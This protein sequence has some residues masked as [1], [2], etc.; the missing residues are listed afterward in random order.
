MWARDRSRKSFGGQG[1]NR[2]PTAE[3]GWS[4]ASGA[5]HLLNLPTV[6]AAPGRDCG[7][8]VNPP[9]DHV[10]SGADD[11]TRTRNLLFTK[12]LLYQLSYV[13][14]TRR[15]IP[16]MTPSAPGNDRAGRSDG[17]SVGG[18]AAA[19]RSG[20]AS[21]VGTARGR[22]GRGLVLGRSRTAFRAESRWPAASCGLPGAAWLSRSAPL[23]SAPCSASAARWLV[24]R[25]PGGDGGD[26]SRRAPVGRSGPPLRVPPRRVLRP[27]P[28]VRRGPGPAGSRWATASNSST[29]PATAALSEPIAPRIG[30]RM[31]RSQRLPD[32]RPET[33]ALAADDDAPADR[34]GRSGARSAARPLSAPAIRS[35]FGRGGRRGRRAGRRPGTSRRCSTAPADAL[36]AAGAE[37]RLAAG[38]EHDAVDAGRLGAAQ[39]RA[40]RSADPRAN[41]G[42]ARTAA[43]RARRHGPGCRRGSRTGAARRRARRPG[44]RRTRR[45]AV[46]EPPS[47]S[48]IGMRSRVAWRT[49]CSRAFRRCGTTSRRRAVRPA[50]KTSSTGRRPA[51]SS[52]SG[53]SRSGG[54]SDGAGRGQGRAAVARRPG[55][56]SGPIGRTRP[57]RA[58]TARIWP[59][60]GGGPPRFGGRRVRVAVALP[61]R[62]GGPPR[63]RSGTLAAAGRAPGPRRAA[64]RRGSGGRHG[65]RSGGGHLARGRRRVA[66]S[67]RRSRRRGR[68]RTVR[69]GAGRGRPAPSAVAASGGR[70]RSG[71]VAPADGPVLGRVAGPCPADRAT[72]AP[73]AAVGRDPG[74]RRIPARRRT[75]RPGPASATAGPAPTGLARRS[76]S[77]ACRPAACR[78]C[79]PCHLRLG[80]RAPSA[81]RAVSHDRP[82]RCAASAARRACPRPSRRARRAHHAAGP[83]PPSRAARAPRPAR[84]AAPRSSGSRSSSGSRRAGPPSTRSRSRS[85]VERPSGVRRRQR[86][87]ARSAG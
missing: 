6:A 55:P 67:M 20:A 43:R 51:T 61:S 53:P 52:S 56:R 9:P 72:A 8:V 13:G 18:R 1:G 7:P 81:V 49:S 42:R 76:G 69:G 39:E 75:V 79:R 34:A 64:L 66:R 54:G 47:T 17:S 33:L 87:R 2:T 73:S 5:H 82:R 84:R 30:I 22:P 23:V 85:V 12:Q 46:S 35:P 60:A 24:A 36:T 10:R 32:G 63:S 65:P 25:P 62:G 31:K 45:C 86:P 68:A 4:T 3:G 41:R 37:R 74:R 83:T 58:A 19:R 44:G 71:P 78:A 48:T 28:D 21:G 14:A 77:R 70:P 16:Q 57:G 15:V 40:R 38:R 80:P 27:A 11:G 29:E 26:A 50:A 59:R